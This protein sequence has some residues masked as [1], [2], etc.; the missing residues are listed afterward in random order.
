MRKMRLVQYGDLSFQ[1][2]K[3]RT[4]LMGMLIAL[5]VCFLLENTALAQL[6]SSSDD[7]PIEP[8]KQEFDRNDYGVDSVFISE[9]DVL[10][11]GID[12]PVPME[13]YILEYTGESFT[14]LSRYAVAQKRMNRT[15]EDH[16]FET[17]LHQWLSNEFY[18]EA[19]NDQEKE[20]IDDI[21][22]LNVGSKETGI[23]VID[24]HPEIMRLEQTEDFQQD[25]WWIDQCVMEWLPLVTEGGSQPESVV[26]DSIRPAYERLI[27]GKIK[28]DGTGISYYLGALYYA[29][30]EDIQD[31][32]G[33][34]VF[35]YGYPVNEPLVVRPKLVV[36]KDYI[37]GMKGIAPQNAQSPDA[38]IVDEVIE[39]LAYPTE[40]FYDTLE[41]IFGDLTSTHFEFSEGDKSEEI[42]ESIRIRCYDT[43][44]WNN[45]RIMGFSFGAAR[46]QKGV[47]E[48]KVVHRINLY[49]EDTSK[50]NDY[51]VSEMYANTM[52]YYDNDENWTR[53]F[54][55]YPYQE[56]EHGA[57]L[58]VWRDDASHSASG[59]ASI[60]MALFVPC[61]DYDFETFFS[62]PTTLKD[63]GAITPNIPV[64]CTPSPIPSVEVEPEYEE[65][66]DESDLSDGQEI[67][68]GVL[69][70]TGQA[71]GAAGNRIT[72]T[73]TIE[74]DCIVSCVIDDENATEHMK[75]GYDFCIQVLTGKSCEYVKSAST[76]SI[77]ND[78]RKYMQDNGHSF[79][80]GGYVHKSINNGIQAVKAAL[81][82]V[83]N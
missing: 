19:F 26:P 55:L 66:N 31:P 6:A 77:T 75:E 51:T 70:G 3:R 82:Q 7:L 74:N 27:D 40:T 76:K 39:A 73:V 83:S 11:D 15:P 12:G 41:P 36:S 29:V 1:T 58:R 21:S 81:K 50:E 79:M 5:L 35:E 32:R 4:V 20:A 45:H 47:Y 30:A 57:G 22:L 52:E 13:W 8:E 16:W 78:V 9:Y 25:K 46:F 23:A 14:L 18:R 71:N 38:I 42:R 28:K 43:L 56:Q 34:S 44:Y 59:N 48:G 69:I 37:F 72:A 2:E 64:D 33:Y 67:P 61:P 68:S 49:V 53:E 54:L 24:E 62:K 65:E 80:S 10:N 63:D 17:E 60:E